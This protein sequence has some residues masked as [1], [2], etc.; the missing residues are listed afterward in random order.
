MKLEGEDKLLRI[1]REM[2]EIFTDRKLREVH[3]RAAQPLVY[4]M[5][6]LAPVGRT[7][8]LADSIGI[9]NTKEDLGGIR[10]GARRKGGFK[11]FAAHLVEFGTKDRYTKRSFAY[12]G[13]MKA[14]PFIEPATDQTLPEV[15]KNIVKEEAREVEKFLKR[16]V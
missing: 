16:R 14:E 4:R 6:R 13:K 2:P 1:F 12:R 10:V 11:G 3:K 5:H 8:N 15:E 9:E 7:G